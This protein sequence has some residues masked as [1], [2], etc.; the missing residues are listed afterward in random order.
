MVNSSTSFRTAPESWMPICLPNFNDRAFLH[1]YVSYLTPTYPGPASDLCLV[2]VSTDRDQFF[3]M[4]GCKKLIFSNLTQ[5]GALFTLQESIR[6]SNFYVTEV[7]VNGLKHFMYKSKVNIQF[8]QSLFHDTLA[9]DPV[10]QR[11]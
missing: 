6:K 9:G 4:S 8:I 1:A 5:S 10:E 7:G 3:S 11:R 2:L